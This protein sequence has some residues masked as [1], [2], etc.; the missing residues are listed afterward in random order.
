MSFK[1]WNL[2]YALFWIFFPKLIPNFHYV[3]KKYI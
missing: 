1:I 3:L 2:S